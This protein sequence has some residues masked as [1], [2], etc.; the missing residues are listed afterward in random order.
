MNIIRDMYL[1]TK[2]NMHKIVMRKKWKRDRRFIVGRKL[3]LSLFLKARGTLSSHLKSTKL[4][5][6]DQKKSYKGLI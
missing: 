5:L 2:H 1:I 4:F 3:C 6:F